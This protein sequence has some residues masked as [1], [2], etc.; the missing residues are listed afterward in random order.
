MAALVG[1][2]LDGAPHAEQKT[3]TAEDLL[4]RQM[5]LSAADLRQLRAGAAIVKSLESSARHELVHLAAV[6]IRKRSDEFI[7]RFRDIE[8]FERGPGIP[9]IGRFSTPPRLEDLASLTIPIDDVR[10]LQACRPGNCALKLSAEAMHR[11]RAEVQ[12][13]S[14]TA[15]QQA[16]EAIKRMLLDLVLA[17]QARGNAALGRY[18]DG[19]QSLPVAE[20]FNALLAQPTLAPVPVPTL[21]TYLR[22]VPRNRPKEGEEFFYWA[23]VQFG[24]KPTIRLNHVVIQ[25]LAGAPSGVTYAIATKQIYASHYFH[26]TLELR[27]LLEDIGA[28]RPAFYLLSIVRSRNDGMTGFSGSLLRPIINRRSRNAVRGYLDYV[29]RQMER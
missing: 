1:F 28:E 29:K 25:P 22:D 2:A 6:R 24:L 16:G 27:F 20:E 26:T 13:T 18:D 23:V 4:Q 19:T 9:Q 5:S 15:T 21:L 10:A 3:S 7:A 11:L 17:Y 8:R 14:P 12:W